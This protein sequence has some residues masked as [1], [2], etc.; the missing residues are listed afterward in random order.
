MLLFVLSKTVAASGA[1]SQAW[2]EW[3]EGMLAKVLDRYDT[4]DDTG[5]EK[6]VRMMEGH[7]HCMV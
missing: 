5:L 7:L 4:T 6:H 2:R 1:H 3:L